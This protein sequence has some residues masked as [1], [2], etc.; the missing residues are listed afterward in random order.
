MESVCIWKLQTTEL[1]VLGLLFSSAELNQE[2]QVIMCH[3][4]FLP[5]RVEF[6]RV[7]KEAAVTYF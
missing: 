2:C 7:W 5:E 6:Y 3:G 1:E 4:C